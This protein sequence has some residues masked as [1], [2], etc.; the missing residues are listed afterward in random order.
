MS[1][2]SSDWNRFNICSTVNDWYSIGGGSIS[3]GLSVASVAVGAGVSGVALAGADEVPGPA[4]LGVSTGEGTLAAGVLVAPKR[5]LLEP[6]VLSFPFFDPVSAAAAPPKLNPPAGAAAAFL[7]S[8]EAA[9]AGALAPKLNPAG[10]AV[11]PS[12]FLASGAEQV[13]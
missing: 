10:A 4:V 13:S 9:V 11:L 3:L 1:V 2:S 6:G 7:S 8:L 5:F 12:S